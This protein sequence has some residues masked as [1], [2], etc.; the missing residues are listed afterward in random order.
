MMLLAGAF[1]L[2]AA[3][4]GAAARVHLSGWFV[5][6]VSFGALFVVAG[7]RQGSSPRWGPTRG[8]GGRSRA[9]R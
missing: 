6:V 3:A 7:K 9:I 4:G 2:R 8:P 5:V 1:V